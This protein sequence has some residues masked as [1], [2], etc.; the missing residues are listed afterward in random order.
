MHFGSQGQSIAAQQY[1]KAEHDLW[2]PTVSA[3]ASD[4]SPLRTLREVCCNV[5]VR[6]FHL[7]RI[8]TA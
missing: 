2:H 5:S 1:S 3:L 6:S 7:A 4:R 8:P